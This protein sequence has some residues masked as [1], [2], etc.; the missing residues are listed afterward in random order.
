VNEATCR[1]LHPHAILLA[2]SDSSTLAAEGTKHPQLAEGHYNPHD[3]S[4]EA[5]QNQDAHGDRARVSQ[6]AVSW[7]EE[8]GEDDGEQNEAANLGEIEPKSKWHKRV[9]LAE[10]LDIRQ[11]CRFLPSFFRGDR[12]VGFGAG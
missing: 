4:N 6:R 11:K 12:S 8:R 7:R 10:L 9:E 2:P 3:C 5:K 1:A